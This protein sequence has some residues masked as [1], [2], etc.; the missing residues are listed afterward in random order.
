MV[1]YI[2]TLLTYLLLCITTYGQITQRPNLIYPGDEDLIRIVNPTFSWTTSN[3]LN[4]SYEVKIVQL[5]Q[6][7]TPQAAIQANPPVYVGNVNTNLL[8]YP[9]IA[10]K[11]VKGNTYAWQ[12][13]MKYQVGVGERN[14]E[15][16]SPS[17]VRS[18]TIADLIEEK[19]VAQLREAIAP[20][21]YVVHDANLDFQFNT[22][23]SVEQVG[24]SYQIIDM[25]QKVVVEGVEPEKA[26]EE[27][28]Y[29]IYFQRYEQLR[30]RKLRNKFL[31]LVATSQSDD[32]FYLKFALN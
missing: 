18:F 27:G 16:V 24:V 19:C 11:L 13:R 10:P 30:K 6:G 22:K 8:P 26:S 5:L 32:K 2:T 4:H 25:N 28:V 17:E 9:L 21:V 31:T 1:K 3:S 23:K 14:E 15:R 7:Q 12:V 20:E 29:T